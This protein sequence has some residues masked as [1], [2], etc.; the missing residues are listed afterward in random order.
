MREADDQTG[1][2]P[3]WHKYSRR[4]ERAENGMP[5][6]DPLVSAAHRPP[7][8]SACL[9]ISVQLQSDLVFAF[10][11]NHCLASVGMVV[12]FARNLHPVS[13]RRTYRQQCSVSWA[14]VPT[15]H[16]RFIVSSELFGVL[17]ALAES[18]PCLA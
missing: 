18:A 2:A 1:L 8:C 14:V 12:R 7:R 6:T 17:N 13:V 10:S 16:N 5:H 4:G 15:G 11:W 3:D 9:G